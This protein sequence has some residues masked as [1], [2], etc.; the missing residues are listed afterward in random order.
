[1]QYFQIGPMNVCRE[2][3]KEELKKKGFPYGYIPK[4]YEKFKQGNLTFFRI[5]LDGCPFIVGTDDEKS[6]PEIAEETGKKIEPYSFEWLVNV[7]E[8]ARL[9]GPISYETLLEQ[10]QM[11]IR[12]NKAKKRKGEIPYFD[13]FMEELNAA[14]SFVKENVMCYFYH[15][16]S[17]CDKCPK[18]DCKG[19]E[20]RELVPDFVVSP[21]ELSRY[22]VRIDEYRTLSI[23]NPKTHYALF[24]DMIRKIESGEFK[25]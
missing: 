7:V 15:N 16:T 18:E 8:D 21:L 3:F 25:K 12:V 10:L 17:A 5:L 19:R 23:P 4:I 14:P 2:E 6:Y 11:Y 24:C 9:A 22:L 13:A 20:P 1:M